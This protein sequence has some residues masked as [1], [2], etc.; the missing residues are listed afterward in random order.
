MIRGSTILS[1]LQERRRDIESEKRSLSRSIVDHDAQLGILRRD[2][3]IA[4]A[5][6]ARTQLTEGTAL[7]SAVQDLIDERNRAYAKAGQTLNLAEDEIGKLEEQR[8]SLRKVLAD[9]EA[10]LAARQGEID[11]LVENDPRTVALRQEASTL[12]D[13]L[14]AMQHKL[15]RAKADAQEKGLAYEEDEFF[16]YLRKRGYGTETYASTGIVRTLDRWLADLT[17]YREA[18]ADYGRLK[19]IPAWLDDRVE[20]LEA[21]VASIGADLE[22]IRD[23]HDASV[24]PLESAAR[25][26][27]ND[28]DHVEATIS[29][30]R[31]N[32]ANAAKFL[33]AVAKGEDPI[34]QRI[35]ETLISR[36]SN[37]KREALR[38]MAG[39]TRSAE[40]DLALAEIEEIARKRLR[41]SS[42]AD[43][44]RSDLASVDRRLE[45]VEDAE[46]RLKRKGWDRNAAEFDMTSRDQD[47]LIDRLAGGYIASDLFFREV[48]SAY[49]E[50]RAEPEAYTSGSRSGTPNWGG[51]GFGGGTTT[52]QPSRQEESENK[53]T[54]GGAIGGSD[55]G[56]STGGAIGGND[57]DN[58]TGGGF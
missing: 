33:D 5:R 36:L 26:A 40:D 27:R 28:L 47:E 31:L 3:A 22:A 37:E 48:S 57:D 25:K 52:V 42:A 34:Q 21:K 29:A 49:E 54:T 51:G 14:A 56:W 38:R 24:A 23:E 32:E 13:N 15:D 30:A 35:M 50:P 20:E 4:W 46:K 44:M 58:K 43:A 6:F 39:S 53:W 8:N 19:A 17:G 41:I 12:G 10:R 1:K 7:P 45:A 2:E 18:A 16:A 11:A 9:A 55:N